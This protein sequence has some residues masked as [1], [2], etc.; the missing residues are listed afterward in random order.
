MR[1]YTERLRREFLDGDY[2]PRS[3][4]ETLSPTAAWSLKQVYSRILFANSQKEKE[5][6]ELKSVLSSLRTSNVLP[7]ADLPLSTPHS[8]SLSPRSL[9]P[10]PFSLLKSTTSAVNEK[11]AKELQSTDELLHLI[12]QTKESTVLPT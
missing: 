2:T 10:D 8:P 11:T 6:A 9:Q 7:C 3:S 4:R 1:Q 5:I 12:R